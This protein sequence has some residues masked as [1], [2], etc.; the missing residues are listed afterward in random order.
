MLNHQPGR[1]LRGLLASP[2]AA[3]LVL[4]T[5][6]PAACADAG[7]LKIRAMVER[8][9][10][11]N[12]RPTWDGS[13]ETKYAPDFDHQAQHKIIRARNALL[14]KGVE[15]FPELIEALDD[16]RYSYTGYD[17]PGDI[18]HFHV[19]QVC[20]RLI[21]VQVEVYK[22]FV[23][24]EANRPPVIRTPHFVPKS[25]FDRKKA[26][27]KEWWRTRKDMNLHDLQLEA[28]EWVLRYEKN[29]GFKSK[30]EESAVIGALQRVRSRLKSSKEPIRVDWH[31][32]TEDLGQEKGEGTQR[33]LLE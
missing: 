29:R 12:K 5:I 11:P 9:A 24:N 27:V 25:S 32:V 4:A 1:I 16:Q 7:Q 13:G 33:D 2:L 18:R 6:R 3:A 22:Y 8:L 15:S 30:K 23:P 31:G 19:W 14:S 21:E 10:S 17:I 26:L 20:D 28:V